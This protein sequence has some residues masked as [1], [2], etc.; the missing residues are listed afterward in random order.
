MSGE[1]STI[2]YEPVFV[3]VWDRLEA[4]AILVVPLGFAFRLTGTQCGI[5]F[6]V[7]GSMFDRAALRAEHLLRSC[8]EFDAS[9]PVVGCLLVTFS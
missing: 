4:Y 5:R 1:R 9:R 6:P 3:Q 8:L 7:Q 2:P